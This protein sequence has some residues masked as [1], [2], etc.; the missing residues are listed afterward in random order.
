MGVGTDVETSRAEVDLGAVALLPGLVNAHTH[1]E[2]S[3]YRDAVPPA[4]AF[5]LWV[6]GMMAARRAIP[7]PADPRILEGIHAGIAQAEATGTACA[8]V[9]A[10]P[11]MTARTAMAASINAAR[12]ILMG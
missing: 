9:D 4:T 12:I 2:L 1:L 7:D 10:E 8:G 6:E 5:V 11:S 3:C